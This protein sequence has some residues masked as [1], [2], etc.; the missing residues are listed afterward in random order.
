MSNAGKATP[1][2]NDPS[3]G[4]EDERFC[5]VFICQQGD[6]EAKAL[7]L[8]ASLRRHLPQMHEIVAA[9][10]GPEALWGTPSP[11][12]LDALERLS[13]T[14][15]AT[16]NRISPDY[17]IGN[18]IDCLTVGTSCRRIVFLDTDMLLLRSVNLGGLKGPRLGAVPAS[19][20]HVRQEDWARFYADCG[21]PQPQPEMRTLVSNELTAPYFNSGFLVM[22]S[23]LASALADQWSECAIRLLGRS[24]LPQ[25]VRSRFLDQV[26]LPL[27][28]AR[29][30]I[31]ITPL[32][33]DWNFPSWAMR[34]G[35]APPPA[36]FHYQ[37]LGR[38][39]RER[40]T[41]EMFLSLMET[42]PRLGDAILELV[43]IHR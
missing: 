9:L 24:D 18:K 36:F 25:V 26:A 41:E 11:A 30:G 37:A 4:E 42:E 5:F 32:A 8:A 20:A 21:L 34:I 13:V 43:G 27:A 40:P 12:I 1:L 31:E 6:L 3:A 38:L 17:P 35:D 22:E 10:P 7:L 2:T 33:K 23:G 29:L 16:V 39:L 19:A 28:A 14:T 15:V